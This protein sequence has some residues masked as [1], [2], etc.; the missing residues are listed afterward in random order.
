M[1]WYM[2]DRKE[3]MKLSKQSEGCTVALCREKNILLP[4]SVFE[5]NAA[6]LGLVLRVRLVAVRDDLHKVLGKLFLYRNPLHP[7]ESSEENCLINSM[8]ELIGEV[9]ESRPRLA[10]KNPVL[11]LSQCA[12][13]MPEEW[14]RIFNFLLEWGKLCYEEKY[15]ITAEV[16]SL[17][18]HGVS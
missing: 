4:T 7:N 1:L 17:N 18:E 11:Y 14:G 12:G 6:S 3:E 9:E 2:D 5:N 16:K 8:L 13:S 15:V 10:K